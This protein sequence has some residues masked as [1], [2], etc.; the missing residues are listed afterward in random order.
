M[1]DPIADLLIRIK[2]AALSRHKALLVPYSSQKEN[3]AKILQRIGLL[4]KVEVVK[5]KA[6]RNLSL[7]LAAG[8]GKIARIEVKRISK[9]GKRVYVQAK[10]IK[11]FTRGLGEVIISSPL[12]LITAQQALKKKVGGEVLCKIVKLV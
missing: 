7:T 6:K 2:N 3:L 10:K 11:F 4:E 8:E 9:P 12:G 5:E 1:S